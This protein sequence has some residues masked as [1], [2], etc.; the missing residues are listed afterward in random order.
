MNKI[1]SGI[2]LIGV[3]TMVYGITY[4]NGQLVDQ[5]NNLKVKNEKLQSEATKLKWEDVSDQ[6]RITWYKVNVLHHQQP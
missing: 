4:R 3:M 6:D 5:N 1:I 2:L